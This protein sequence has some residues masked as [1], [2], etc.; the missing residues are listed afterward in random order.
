MEGQRELS[1]KLRDGME[2]RRNS[3]VKGRAGTLDFILG[4][5]QRNRRGF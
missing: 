4:A 3:K 1:E 2:D 5:V